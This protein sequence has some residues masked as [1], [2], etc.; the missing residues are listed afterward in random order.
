MQIHP[1]DRIAITTASG[2]QGLGEALDGLGMALLERG[3][4]LLGLLLQLL[5]IGPAWQ[6]RH[7]NLRASDADDPQLGCTKVENLAHDHCKWALPFPRVRVRLAPPLEAKRRRP[8]K[9]NNLHTKARQQRQRRRASIGRLTDVRCSKRYGHGKPSIE[10]TV[11]G[12]EKVGRERQLAM[13]W[14]QSMR[15]YQRR[16]QRN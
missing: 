2:G 12:G 16:R 1:R 7:V 3:K 5:D 10:R 6:R 11:G 4:Q 13:T 8:L 15:S 9:S 14:R